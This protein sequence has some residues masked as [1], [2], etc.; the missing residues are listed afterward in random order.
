MKKYFVFLIFILSHHL[1]PSQT[2]YSGKKKGFIIVDNYFVNIV[3]DTAFLE[4][5]NETGGVMVQSI[6]DTLL[7]NNNVF[8]GKCFLLKP[9]NAKIMEL[10]SKDDC[11]YKLH[12]TVSESPDFDI[13]NYWYMK[14]RV[15]LDNIPLNN[16]PLKE[17]KKIVDSLEILPSDFQIQLERMKRKYNIVILK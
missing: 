15:F 4:H 2:W 10:A 6:A 11:N 13:R 12:I 9:M 7:R 14:N 16:V 1:S 5:F 17:Q 3:K 8:I